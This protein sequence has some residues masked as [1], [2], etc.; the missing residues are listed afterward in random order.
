MDINIYTKQVIL[1]NII[2]IGQYLLSQCFAILSSQKNIDNDG[3][4]FC[5]SVLQGATGNV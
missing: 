4:E 3:V 1:T 2:E 5:N